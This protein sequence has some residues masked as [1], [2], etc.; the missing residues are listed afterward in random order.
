[1]VVIMKKVCEDYVK[2]SKEARKKWP[3]AV[4]LDPT[5][6]GAMEKFDPAFPIG[7]VKVLGSKWME[8]LSIMGIWEGLKVFSKK[9]EIDSGYFKDVKKLGK[10]RG[11]KSYGRL[12]GIKVGDN[13][14]EGEDE[15]VDLFEKL[16]RETIYGRFDF[17][18]ESLKGQA[19]G[20]TVVLLDYKEGDERYPV[21]HVEI[22][23]EMIE[24]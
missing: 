19:E 5:L 20:R 1:M 13:V 2:N 6:G 17:L 24:G 7:K 16:Y 9:N 4:V 15:M 3:G 21:S 14:I 8:S 22:L 23:K 12:V 18:I 11:C 10:V